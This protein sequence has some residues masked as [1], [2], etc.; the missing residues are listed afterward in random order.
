[1]FIASDQPTDA[2]PAN[3]ATALLTALGPQGTAV[4]LL[5]GLAVL[6]VKY[7]SVRKAELQ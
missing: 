5:V 3:L 4:L 7:K 2:A 1:M 6:T